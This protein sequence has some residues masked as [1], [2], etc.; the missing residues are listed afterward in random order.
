MNTTRQL[1]RLLTSKH[2]SKYGEKNFFIKEKHPFKIFWWYDQDELL[3]STF[4]NTK[5]AY[6]S[7]WYMLRSL[8]DREMLRDGDIEQ[9]IK[10][11]QNPK[12]S[13]EETSIHYNK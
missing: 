12:I 7:A 6:K 1:L 4:G 10:T 2:S 8:H 5:S 9:L 3:F 11:I 13:F